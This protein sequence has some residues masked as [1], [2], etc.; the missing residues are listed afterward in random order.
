VAALRSQDN[1]PLNLQFDP[2]FEPLRADDRY[3]K[4]IR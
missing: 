1:L 2:L 3:A 4:L